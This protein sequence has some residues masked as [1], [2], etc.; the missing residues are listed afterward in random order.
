MDWTSSCSL[1][2][3]GWGGGE[4]DSVQE[5]IPD[6]RVQPRDSTN[7]AGRATCRALVNSRVLRCSLLYN[8]N[9][10]MGRRSRCCGAT[11]SEAGDV[12][13]W[14][15][16]AVPTVGVGEA[17]LDRLLN[18]CR[19]SN[20]GTPHT[21][22]C[23]ATPPTIP[24]TAT[25]PGG[26]ACERRERRLPSCMFAGRSTVGPIVRRLCRPQSFLSHINAEVR[27]GDN[28]RRFFCQMLYMHVRVHVHVHADVG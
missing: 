13:P 21:P 2:N 25:A 1:R 11:T 4:A 27:W 19:L 24:L 15:P 10:F 14:E 5:T 28:H 22:E 23:S 17:V 7:G 26:A 18:E 12:A 9:E 16:M 20:P 6:R 3:V 8:R